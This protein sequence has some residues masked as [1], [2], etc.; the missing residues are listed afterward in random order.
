M[1]GRENCIQLQCLPSCI[2]TTRIFHACLLSINVQ[3][4]HFSIWHSIQL[5]IQ[6]IS[7]FLFSSLSSY[8][9]RVQ[10]C[11]IIL[12]TD[13]AQLRVI[14]ICCNI[15]MISEMVHMMSG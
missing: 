15:H 10:M 1:V 5:E 11:K 14:R 8:G 13:K 4:F 3:N 6:D 7:L 9:G 12:P 2:L